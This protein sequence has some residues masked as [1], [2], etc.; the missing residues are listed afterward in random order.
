M[1]FHCDGWEIGSQP[2]GRRPSPIY[3]DERRLSSRRPGLDLA[4]RSE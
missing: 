3:G 2:E 1:K 4:E